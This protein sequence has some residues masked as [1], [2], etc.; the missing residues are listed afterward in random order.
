M[1]IRYFK[2]GFLS[3][4]FLN[5]L[6]GCGLWD[7]WRSSAIRQARRPWSPAPELEEDIGS[8]QPRQ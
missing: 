8:R 2:L 1:E 5:T 6:A 4:F 7:C 3:L